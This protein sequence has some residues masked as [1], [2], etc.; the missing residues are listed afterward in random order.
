MIDLDPHWAF[1]VL[2][3]VVASTIAFSAF[4]GRLLANSN[5]KSHPNEEDLPQDVPSALPEVEDDPPQQQAEQAAPQD[6]SSLPE[7]DVPPQDQ[8]LPQEPTVL[9]ETDAASDSLKDEPLPPAITPP[10]KALRDEN[11][12]TVFI[13]FDRSD[14]DLTRNDYQA[15]VTVLDPRLRPQLC[16]ILPDPDIPL[17]YKPTV[18]LFR[19]LM[20]RSV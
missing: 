4:S 8:V 10:Y 1:N 15:F 13:W 12:N 17:G 6:A 11:N 9:L 18:S 16:R 19:S 3:V 2:S 20:I 5:A 14:E 7:G